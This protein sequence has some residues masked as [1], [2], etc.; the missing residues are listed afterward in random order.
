MLDILYVLKF[1]KKNY[2]Q[3]YFIKKG[4]AKSVDKSAQ[5]ET[6]NKLLCIHT[7]TN[8]Y[9]NWQLNQVILKENQLVNINKWSLIVAVMKRRIELQMRTLK[10]GFEGKTKA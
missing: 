5:I 10:F 4:N 1:A 3:K 2:V 9:T 7:V 8:K 6:I